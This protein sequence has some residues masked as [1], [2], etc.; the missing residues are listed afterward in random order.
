MGHIEYLT[1]VPHNGPKP[2]NE[3][4]YNLKNTSVLFIHAWT[5][6]PQDLQTA[7]KVSKEAMIS[8]DHIINE[9]MRARDLLIAEQSYSGSD[10]KTVLDE[11]IA[12]SVTNVTRQQQ[13]DLANL[14]P[15]N[16]SLPLQGISISM[17]RLL[18]K[19]KHR[20][21]DC[22]NFRVGTQK[23]HYFLMAVDKPNKSP[24][25]II[26]FVVADF[27]KHCEEVNAVI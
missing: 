4:I 27:C 19:V 3:S 18:N 5:S 23:D 10:L 21:P 17:E 6:S 16:G 1:G 22:I 20:R 2:L 9:I 14:G 12:L 15:G 8:L 25:S 26:E 7:G 24:D 13:H 11:Q